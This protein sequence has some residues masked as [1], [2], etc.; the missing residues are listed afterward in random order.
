MLNF[1]KTIGTNLF[2]C[3]KSRDRNKIYGLTKIVYLNFPKVF[4]EVKNGHL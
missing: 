2:F 1:K 4:R 3:K